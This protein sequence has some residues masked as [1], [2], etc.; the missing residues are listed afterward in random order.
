MYLEYSLYKVLW[1]LTHGVSFKP[2]LLLSSSRTIPHPAKYKKGQK[3][4]Q[5]RMGGGKKGRLEKDKK[6]TFCPHFSNQ[7][8]YRNWCI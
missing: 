1:T 6:Y 2:S 7:L 3:A 8:N 5:G 4:G